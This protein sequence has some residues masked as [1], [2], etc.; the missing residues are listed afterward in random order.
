MW[1]WEAIIVIS[2]FRNSFSQCR[3]QYIFKGKTEENN[4][5]YFGIYVTLNPQGWSWTLSPASSSITTYYDYKALQKNKKKKRLHSGDAESLLLPVLPP[6]AEPDRCHPGQAGPNPW[7]TSSATDGSW[8]RTG[9]SDTNCSGG[10]PSYWPG[11]HRLY[12]LVK[13]S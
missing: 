12:Q 11:S 6:P 13:I 4:H 10:A 5:P 7:W 2:P 9:H 3:Y 8:E 1:E